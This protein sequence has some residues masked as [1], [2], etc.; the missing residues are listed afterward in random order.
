MGADGSNRVGGWGRTV[1][2]GWG[3]GVDGGLNIRV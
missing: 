2:I 1:V 3:V